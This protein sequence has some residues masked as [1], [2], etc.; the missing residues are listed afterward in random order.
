M[1]ISSRNIK[2]NVCAFIG[3]K[4]KRCGQSEQWRLKIM[5]QLYLP[6]SSEDRVSANAKFGSNSNIT[7]FYFD[8]LTH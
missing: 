2:R 8:C 7:F 6:V 4:L 5:L 3:V 1:A